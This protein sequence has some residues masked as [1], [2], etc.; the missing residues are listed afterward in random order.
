VLSTSASGLGSFVFECIYVRYFLL[1]IFCPFDQ[2]QFSRVYPKGQRI[3]SSN[4]NPIQLWNSGCQ[5]VALNYQTAGKG[6]ACQQIVL[7]FGTEKGNSGRWQWPLTNRIH[8]D[9]GSEVR[10]PLS[11]CH[12]RLLCGASGYPPNVLQPLETY[13]TNPALVSPFHLQRCSM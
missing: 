13:C 8:V 12:L 2:V 1:L 3:D 11:S 9:V 5:M 7:Y 10:W 6:M 4:Y